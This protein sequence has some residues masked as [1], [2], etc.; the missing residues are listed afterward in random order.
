MIV[1]GGRQLRQQPHRGR[2]FQQHG[3]LSLRFDPDVKYLKETNAIKVRRQG[4]KVHFLT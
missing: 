2:H 4:Y 3:E 1:I